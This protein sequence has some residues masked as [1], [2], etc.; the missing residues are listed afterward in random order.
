MSA[1]LIGHFTIEDMEGYE[2]Y[3]DAFPAIFSKYGGE[4]VAFD[5]DAPVLEGGIEKGRTVLLRFPDRQ[6]ALAWYQS[7]E[8]QAIAKDR[9]ASCRTHFVTIIDERPL[10]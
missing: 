4:I 1:Y 5:D 7:P 6:T 2:R 8:Y 3:R 9:M 10:T